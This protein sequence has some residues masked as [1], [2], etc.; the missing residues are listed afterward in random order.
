MSSR[1]LFLLDISFLGYGK[2]T[3]LDEC[4]F[5]ECVD[6]EEFESAR[7]LRIQPPEGEVRRCD[8]S[9]GMSFL[10]D[11]ISIC[12]SLLVVLANSII[13]FIS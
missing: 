9:F 8:N 3:N 11:S 10:G 13:M 6:Q 12:I 2:M 1:F 5:H 7:M 4:S